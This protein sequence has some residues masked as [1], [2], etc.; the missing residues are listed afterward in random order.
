[1]KQTRKFYPP[2]QIAH[3]LDI[4]RSTM[5]RWVKDGLIPNMTHLSPCRCGYSFELMKYVLDKTA[6]DETVSL[7]HF[8]KSY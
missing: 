7:T 8:D 4:D 1:M 2:K 6:P 3:E 5:Y